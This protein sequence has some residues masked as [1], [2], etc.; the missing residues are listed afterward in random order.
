MNAGLLIEPDVV[1]FAGSIVKLRD[2][3][4]E[5]G[6]A[7]LTDGGHRPGSCQSRSTPVNWPRRREPVTGLRVRSQRWRGSPRGGLSSTGK[8]CRRLQTSRDGY[9]LGVA[10]QSP[11]HYRLNSPLRDAALLVL[12][13]AVAIPIM[14][15]L[16][17]SGTLAAMTL[18]LGG[19]R[20][21][22]HDFRRMGT[23]P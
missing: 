6:S 23:L 11:Q 4:T 17:A 12:L 3:N 22:P 8:H 10:H 21:R 9:I 2:G 5:I 18:I 14:L 1:S 19:W 16:A 13:T 15:T 7:T 20:K